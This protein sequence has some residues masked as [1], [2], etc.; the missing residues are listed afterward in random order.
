[1]SSLRRIKGIPTPGVE[2][3]ALAGEA[4]V[5]EWVDPTTLLVD[6]AY[7]R[8]LA[9]RSVTLIRKVVGSFSWAS[10]KPPIC[11]RTAAGLEVI[12]GQH[13]AIAAAS[14][15]DVERI[16]VMV[17]DAATLQGR[18]SAFL[19]HNRDRV[20]MTPTQMHHAAVAAGDPD[21]VTIDQVCTRAKVK[22]MRVQPSIF[23]PRETVA[24]AAIG[25]LIKRRGAMKARQVLDVVA[26]TGMAPVSMAALKAVEHVLF[27][28]S[29]GASIKLGDLTTAIRA[30]GDTAEKEG[31]LFAAT[32]DV[33]I[34]RGLAAVY[35][36][37][38]SR[39][40][41]P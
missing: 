16:P 5:C 41:R 15:P 12:D 25:A 7:Q 27:V 10:F 38:V 6:G 14:H 19:G 29:A 2:P 18:A 32:H 26:D 9:E 3:A 20:A 8:N 4:P 11:A 36:R 40:R 31:R 21:A 24:V 39:A 13:S 23:G 1:M 30:L 37:K 33:P 34:W 35:L 28:E 22:V 17:V